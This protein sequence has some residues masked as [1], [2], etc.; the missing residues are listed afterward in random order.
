[1]NLRGILENIKNFLDN[2]NIFASYYYSYVNNVFTEKKLKYPLLVYH[3]DN[4]SNNVI[5]NS[6]SILNF[7]FYIFDKLKSDNSNIT[8]IQDDLLVRLNYFKNYLRTTLYATD[9]TITAIPDEAYSEKITGW[10]MNCKIRLD[11]GCIT[12]LWNPSFANNL[13]LWLKADSGVVYDENN[14]V[15]QWYDASGNGYIFSQNNPDKQPLYITSI[16][17][18]NHKPAIKFDNSTLTSTQQIT[19]GTF[20]ILTNYIYETFQNYSGLLTSHI[21]NYT[22]KDFILVSNE[23]GTSFFYI[24][25]IGDNLFINNIQTYDFSPLKKPKLVYGYLNEIITWDHIQI[26]KDRNHDR[27][28]HGD[29]YEV[30]IYDRVLSSTEIEKVKKYLKEKYAMDF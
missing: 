16:D 29:I 19:I 1:M 18:M 22:G 8:E 15:S 28:W 6:I 14:K 5:E 12:S 30:I 4:S 24:D 21:D 11:I 26:G 9:F 13:K 7:N 25:L 20:F 23:N 10:I 17:S 2:E 27:F 3:I